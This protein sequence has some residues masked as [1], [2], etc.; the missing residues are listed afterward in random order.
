MTDQSFDVIVVGAGLMGSAAARHLA[1]MGARTALI[2]PAEPAVKAAHTGVFASHYDQARITRKIDTR[3]NWGRFAQAAIARYGE[4]EQKGG[5]PF[6]SD[7]GAVIAGPELGRGR[8]FILNAQRN[9]VADGVVHQALRGLDLAT[10]FPDFV[11]PQGIL[12]LYEPT[13][14]GWINPR[15]HVSAEIAAAQAA[16]AYVRRDTVAQITEQP[17]EARVVCV[18]GD[19]VTAGKVIVACGAFSK[20]EGLLPDPIPMDVYARTIAFFELDGAEAARLAGM[21]SVVYLPPDLRADPYILPPVRYPD[22][23]TYIKIGGDAVDRKLES[24]AEMID[25]F[26]SGGDPVAGAAMAEILTGLM[27]GLA[28]R[29]ISFDSCATSFS[30]NGNPFIYPQSDQIIALTAGN[31]AGAKSADE[32]GRLGAL[33]ATGEAIPADL[34]EGA[35]APSSIPFKAR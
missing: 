33:V 11:F 7:V 31:G 14:A 4:I 23:K 2:G 19:V 20:A 10:R 18:G 22:G 24:A 21:P 9:A 5:V 13:E 16:G 17:G 30:P 6:F 27:P 12:A 15:A 25:W 28:F 32:L 8:D 26:R 3:K 1:E 35:F 29:S 34:Y